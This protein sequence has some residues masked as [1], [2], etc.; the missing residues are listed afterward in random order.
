M[1]LQIHHTIPG[2]NGEIRRIRFIHASFSDTGEQ[3]ATV[4]HR[5]NIFIIDLGSSKFWLVE[6]VGSCTSTAFS[7]NK[8]DEVLAAVT[9]GTI[10][11]LNTELGKTTGSLVGH[12][13]P[14]TQMSFAKNRYCLS[15][16]SQEAI[17][18]DL[19]SNSQAHRL[20]MRNNVLVKKV[21]FMPVTSYILACFQDDAMHV[22]KFETFEF[23]KQIVPDA[24]KNHHIKTIAFTRNGRAMVIGGHSPSLVIFS[25][26]DWT[27][28][29]VVDLPE[30]I[31]GA[32]HVEFVPQLFDGGANRI[33]AILSANCKVHFLDTG[34]FHFL[35][36][37]IEPGSSIR[38]FTCSP[39]G[40]YITIILR[41][42]EINVYSGAKLLEEKQLM[43]C[44]KQKPKEV[45]RDSPD[46]LKAM[47]QRA[48]TAAQDHLAKLN[49]Q[50]QKTLD[51]ERLRP[52]LK[53]FGEYPESYRALIWKTILKVP[54]NQ[55]AFV[56]LVKRDCH[57]AYLNLDQQY[58][59]ENRAMLKNLQRLLSC[60]AH[61]CPLFG[62]VK[63]LPLFVFPFVRVFQNDPF[64]CF[65]AVTTI[66]VNWC[67]YWFEY[68]PFPPVNVLA[69]IENVLAEH[70]PELLQFFARA[71]ITSQVYAWPLLE[72]S[73]SEVLSSL[74][75]LQFWDHVLSNEPSFLLMAVV[76]YN[77]VCRG[78]LQSCKEPSDF[79]FFFHN[80][81][82]IDM[83]HF[84]AKT[85][86]LCKKTKDELH[87]R[88]Y[89]SEF[90]PLSK[91]VYPVFTQYPKFVVDSKAEQMQQLRREEQKLL[92]EQT[93]AME[94][95]KVQE[96][97]IKEETR[98][99]LQEARLMKLEDAY[100]DTLLKEEERLAEKR[101]KIAS[102]RR[103]LRSRELRLLDTAREKI[104]QQQVT[105]RHFALDRLL[106]DLAHKRIQEDSEMAVTEQQLRDHYTELL[107][108]KH[109]LEER[110]G[111]PHEAV[112]GPTI[113]H[114]ILQKQQEKL[115]LELLRLR[116]E[117]SSKQLSR[118]AEMATRI[119]VVDDLL[120][121]V[122]VELAKE[123]AERQNHLISSEGNVKIMQLEKETQSLELQVE[124]LLDKLS[125]LRLLESKSRL[126]EA[127]KSIADRRELNQEQEDLFQALGG[128]KT[129][130]PD[131]AHLRRKFE[132][133]RDWITDY[134]SKGYT[135]DANCSEGPNRLRKTKDNSEQAEWISPCDTNVQTNGL[136]SEGTK[137]TVAVKRTTGPHPSF[138]SSYFSE[139]PRYGYEQDVIESAMN[140]RKS[141]YS[142]NSRASSPLTTAKRT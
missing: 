46:H 62:E 92:H 19:T 114:T 31:S 41:S 123:M 93:L 16:S 36:V 28:K 98:A 72:A 38:T 76:A 45:K 132:R 60:L 71:E 125:Q 35:G 49:K 84:L 25:L 66:L 134:L 109:K 7:P 70:D 14:V 108:Q 50:I 13:T 118:R 18:W 80:Q 54:G 101:K 8:A 88:Q 22:W 52:I 140:A 23:I 131:E 59:L 39:T 33:L 51:L 129:P 15:A 138:A 21:I 119:A 74:E 37:T 24:W 75:W 10:Q 87:P 139:S 136:F 100:R 26:D 56:G 4:D 29:R 142:E 1:V 113:E 106:D 6:N 3:L 117:A 104:M 40:K 133:T 58:P 115:K 127:A 57:S 67:R 64:T 78:A 99:D 85:Y 126:Q 63:Y 95:K 61:W 112:P 94:Q 43:E 89:L 124:H 121:R 17:I 27:V 53:E 105:R 122:E 137:S 77:I 103:D 120:Q 11:I 90:K 69:M 55:A 79:E 91:G 135:S 116:E 102:L 141:M 97:R 42:G 9:T 130:V 48:K 128:L 86:F 107:I 32:T 111:L 65:E 68:F 34:S 30:E 96:Q 12:T 20:S 73:F 2:V 82:P 81:N 83:K 5:G 110:V 47:Q 44:D